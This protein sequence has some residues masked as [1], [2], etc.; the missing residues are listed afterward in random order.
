MSQTL[1]SFYILGQTVYLKIAM[2]RIPGMV[3]SITENID[4]S[5]IFGVTWGTG[6]EGRYY[7][8]EL[9]EEYV[10]DLGD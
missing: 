9:A 6:N 7:A 1:T 8:A 4:G 2:E 10:P 5:V 3:T